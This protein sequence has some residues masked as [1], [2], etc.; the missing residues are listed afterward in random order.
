M[1]ISN[2][3]GLPDHMIIN[4]TNKPKD[5]TLTILHVTDLH[6][7]QP[8]YEWIT[9]QIESY[10]IL[11]L[12]GDLIEHPKESGQ[13]EW[14]TAWLNTLTKPTFICSGNH[15]IEK[16]SISNEELLNLDSS[17]DDCD[18]MDWDTDRYAFTEK[19]LQRKA[20]FWMNTISNKWVYAD[21]TI[22]KIQH[23]TIGCAPCNDPVLPDFNQCDIL[24]HHLPPENTATSNQ[25]GKD[26]G[27]MDLYLALTHEHI[28]P[29]YVLCG[30]VHKPKSNKD[31]IKNTIVL[32]PGA[33]FDNDGPKHNYI[34]L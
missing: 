20:S 8:H 17:I 32:N 24:L 2:I 11:C 18:P 34:T 9:Q 19:A 14:V 16:E 23:I 21:N 22:R 5:Q 25:K 33:T 29:H 3:E 4:E 6:S 30:H 27:C 26:W 15:D 12:S 7:H 10:D 28:K 31:Q 1:L 13:V